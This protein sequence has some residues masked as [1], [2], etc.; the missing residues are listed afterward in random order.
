METERRLKGLFELSTCP[1]PRKQRVHTNLTEEDI[2]GMISKSV[3]AA[4]DAH[5]L[6]HENEEQISAKEEGKDF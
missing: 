4:L 1:E 6:L 3:T 5:K 2:A